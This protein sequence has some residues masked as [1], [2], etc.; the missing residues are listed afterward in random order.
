MPPGVLQQTTGKGI[1]AN[2]DLDA[3]ISEETIW[4]NRGEGAATL[5][6]RKSSPANRFLKVAAARTVY[7]WRRW[8]SG[9]TI[10]NYSRAGLSTLVTLA[11]A[12]LAI[13]PDA[14]LA[15]QRLGVG[16]RQP[17]ASAIRS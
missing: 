10:G 3:A 17:A 8:R 2:H 4:G 7:A 13:G 9:A 11:L 14:M 15:D 16:L 12:C 1:A 6:H 5:H